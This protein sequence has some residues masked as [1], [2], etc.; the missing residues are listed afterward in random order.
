[1]PKPAGAGWPNGIVLPEG[2]LNNPSLTWLRRWCEEKAKILAV[3]S[4]PEETFRSA[5]ATVKASLVFLKRF[6][7]EDQKAWDNAWADAHAAYDVAFNAERDKLTAN[8]GPRILSGDDVHA[9]NF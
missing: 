1:M 2:N 7:E 9:A 6:T 3:I 5:D 8:Y 4:L